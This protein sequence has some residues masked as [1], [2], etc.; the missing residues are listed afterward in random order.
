MLEV[1]AAIADAIAEGQADEAEQLM[2]EHMQQY[3][4]WVH[5]LHP[6]C[7][8][9]HRLAVDGRARPGGRLAQRPRHTGARFSVKA[10]APS[11]AS[12]DAR[13]GA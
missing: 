2:R 3:A 12:S 9:R 7:W 5:T 6:A 10:R 11:W 1:H 8:T 13:T 4:D